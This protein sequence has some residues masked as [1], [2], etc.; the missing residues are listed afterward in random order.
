LSFIIR[1][2][3][4]LSFCNDDLLDLFIFISKNPLSHAVLKLVNCD[5]KYIAEHWKCF[6]I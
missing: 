6:S 3:C 4:K 5:D 2:S 1:R